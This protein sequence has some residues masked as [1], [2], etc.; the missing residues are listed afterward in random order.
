MVIPTYSV[1]IQSQKTLESFAQYQPLFAQAVRE[2]TVG[3]CKWIESGTTL[4]TALPELA[5]LTDD[6]QEWRAVIV[7]Y[8]DDER[9]AAFETDPRNPYDFLVNRDGGEQ[10]GESPIPLVRLTQMLGGV[11]P[12]EVQFRAEVVKEDRKAAR[13]IYVPVEDK[14][15]EQAY[16]KLVRKYR[17]D[18]KMPSAILIIT[19]RDVRDRD[20]GSAGREWLAHRESD[21]SEFWKRNHFPSVCRFTAYDFQAQGPIQREADNFGFWY[22]VMLMAVNEWDSSTL[23]AYRLYTLDAVMDRAAMTE[24]F[25]TLADRLRDARHCIQRSIRRD[26]EGGASEEQPLPEYRMEV[27][28]AVQRPHMEDCL[29]QSRSFKLLSPGANS[30][31]ASW[32]SQKKRAEDVLTRSIRSAGRTLDQTADKIRGNCSLSEEEASPLNMYQEEDL[33]RELGEFYDAIVRIQGKLPGEDAAQDGEIQEAASAVRSYLLGRVMRKPALLSLL[34]AAALLALSAVPAV[35]DRVLY[36]VGSAYGIALVVG[37]SALLVLL[38]ALGV[39][40]VQRV[41]L[42]FLV[43]KY[44]QRMKDAFNQLTERAGDYSDYMSGIASHAR[45]SSYLNLSNRKK[46]RSTMEHS[47]KYRHLKAIG[48]MLGRLNRWSRAFRLDVDFSAPRPET[49]LDVDLSV[50]PAQN[51]FYQFDAAA[52]HVVAVNSSGMNMES[53]Y[54]FASR[55]EIVRE[56]LY[57]D[58]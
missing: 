34:L 32:S 55:I 49:R 20:E 42:H 51:K 29:P 6:K 35:L 3:V 38:A 15:R 39:L 13:T 23:Q 54:P 46:H 50:P 44:V 22:S 16:R 10:M 52:P 43:R 21:S 27:P 18:G 41:K 1:I 33:Q 24:S 8:E 40:V 31:V 36:E 9:M 25:Q 14:E 2:G 5:G 19:A 45:G 12:L 58:E 48:I 28:V 53:P 4:D 26:V 7:R 37:A 17:Y 56:E 11:P 57:D 30:D 47:T